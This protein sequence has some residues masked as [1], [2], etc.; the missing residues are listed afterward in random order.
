MMANTTTAVPSL[1]S[2]FADDGG[3]SGFDA[4]ADLRMPKHGNGV[5]RRDQRAGAAGSSEIHPAEQRK[6]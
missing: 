5:D 2:D 1:N 6:V 4:P 3:A